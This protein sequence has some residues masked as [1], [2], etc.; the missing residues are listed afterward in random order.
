[1]KTHRDP[2]LSRKSAPKE[3]FAHGTD[4][5]LDPREA[6]AQELER[7]NRFTAGARV[8]GCENPNSPFPNWKCRTRACPV[9]AQAI[10]D[11]NAAR[12]ASII[13]KMK[14]PTA[15]LVTMVSTSLWDLG[16][17]IDAFHE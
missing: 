6:R 4:A 10:A 9:C 2:A 14:N 13:S 11:R 3:T 15:V 5:G 7:T 16:S 12:A 17:T 1:M 8:R